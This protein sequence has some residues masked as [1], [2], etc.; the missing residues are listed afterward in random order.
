MVTFISITN[1]RRYLGSIVARSRRGEYFIIEKRGVPI[2]GI[3][4]ADEL[5][6][7]VELQNPKIQKQI[8]QGRRDYEAGRVR[9]ARELLA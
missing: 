8:A 1:A 6:D 3:L 9:D 4:D 7:D 5:E 2:A